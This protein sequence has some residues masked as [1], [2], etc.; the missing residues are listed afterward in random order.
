MNINRFNINYII[1]NKDKFD[2][3]NIICNINQKTLNKSFIILEYKLN[4]LKLDGLYFETPKISL[5]NNNMISNSLSNK[6][7]IDIPLIDNIDH[8][9]FNNIF[10]NIDKKFNEIIKKQSS[11]L[12][13]N[14]SVKNDVIIIKNNK[15]E[16]K[17]IKCKLN[18]NECNIFY[19]NKLYT[20]AIE[21]LDFTNLYIKCIISCYGFWKHEHN[22]GLSWKILKLDIYSINKCK[23]NKTVSAMRN[24]N[25]FK[26]IPK[27]EQKKEQK[28]NFSEEIKIPN[29]ELETD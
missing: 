7:N 4:I 9:H 6:Y 2:V 26:I 23:E 8:Y 5:F 1:I 16:Y 28:N 3:D 21:K 18:T 11:H 25:L 17:F 22:I 19:N 29:F 14:N 10:I 27:Y 15:Y 20:D 13:Y 12:I 24:E